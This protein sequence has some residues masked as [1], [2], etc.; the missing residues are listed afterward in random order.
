MSLDPRLAQI[1]RQRTAIS[2]GGISGYVERLIR[3]DQLAEAVR[4]VGDWY[5]AHPNHVEADNAESEAAE[6]ERTRM[7]A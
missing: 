6:A 5:A 4:T 1:V 2:P 3:R 7:S